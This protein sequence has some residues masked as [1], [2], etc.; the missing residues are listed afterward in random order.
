[1][2]DF[3]LIAEKAKKFIEKLGKEI[4]VEKLGDMSSKERLDLFESFLSKEEAKNTNLLLE[5]KLLRKNREDALISWIEETTGKNSA[6]KQEMKDRIKKNS[7]ER[8]KRIF[9]PEDDE[10]FL[11][12]LV[13]QRLGI[14]ISQKESETIFKLSKKFQDT[15]DLFNKSKIYSKLDEIKGKISVDEKKIVDDLIAKLEDKAEAKKLNSQ[16][17]QRI[18]RYLGE[19]ADLNTK[20]EINKLVD[21]IVSSHRQEGLAFGASKVALDKYIG[22]IKLGIKTPRTI[23]STIKDVA[24]FAKSTKASVDNSFIGRQGLKTLFSGHPIVW[25]KSMNESFRLLYKAGIKGEE[26]LQ[27]LKAEILSRKNSRN[28]LYEK[29]KLAVGN[30]EE[31]YPTNLPEKIPLL[32]RVFKG[33]EEAFT[34][35]AYRMRADLADVIIKKAQ[36]QGIDLTDKKQLESIGELINSMTGRGSIKG[37][38]EGFQEA[39]NV[40]FFS[41]KYLKSQLDTV[42]HIFTGAGGSNFV[43]KEAA[44]NLVG[45]VS[46]IAGIMYL[47]DKLQPGS[48]EWDMRSSDFGKIKIGN[49]RFDVTGGL[50]SLAVLAARIARQSS[51]STT[52]NITNMSDYGSRDATALV[53]DFIENKK[54]PLI[55]IISDMYSG[56]NFDKEPTGWEAMKNKPVDTFFTL[57]KGFI[58][59]IPVSNAIEAYKNKETEPALASVILDGL[60]I[61]AKTYTTKENWHSKTTKEMKKLK[62]S[63]GYNKFDDANKEFNSQI[64]K[65]LEE[66][67]KSKEF[68]ELSAEEK[69]K[70]LSAAKKELKEEIITKYT[71]EEE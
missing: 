57:G 55:S 41:P 4:Q 18:K 20:A 63:I 27:G 19:G 59:P 13:D 46:S 16:S 58:S 49:T 40:A 65:K 11:N 56:E 2:A 15:K 38:S 64:N 53:G 1:M 50:G 30:M 51:K 68:M 9:S 22:D 52:G 39:L 45:I 33:S 69:A 28:G 36:K 6:W 14:G 32:G 35:S 5:R 71:P 67:K 42:G 34:G 60:G 48:V 23:L 17:L 8:L 70:E 24:S 29:M 25:L 61:G 12:E 43:R 21:D 10:A 44:K 37:A 62:E 47:A 7:D 26:A 54:S 31:A 3:C 66:L